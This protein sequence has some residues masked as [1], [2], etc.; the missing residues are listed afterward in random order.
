MISRAAVVLLTA[1]LLGGCGHMAQDE[2]GQPSFGIEFPPAGP[3]ESPTAFV[4]M[5]DGINRDIF[6]RMLAEGRLPNIKRFFV[7]RGLYCDRCVVNVPS[8]TLVN[9]TSLVT[10]VFSGRHG[11]MGND[12]FDR[13]ALFNRNYDDLAEKNILDT[14]YRSAT[15]FE[16]LADETTMSLFYQAHRGASKYAENWT[17]AGPPYFFGMYSLVDQIS[18]W[19][20]EI[21]ANVAR[22][23]GRFPRTSG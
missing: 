20:F 10:S 12:W 5:V 13:S 8:V 22:A 16:R 4:F 15:L 1:V 2:C 19:R 11:V 14:D 18:L 17:S 6:D 9:E 23:Q 3:A 7:D 21:V